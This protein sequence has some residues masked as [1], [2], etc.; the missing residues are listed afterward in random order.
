M[1]KSLPAHTAPRNENADAASLIPH[2][3]VQDVLD[4]AYCTAHNYPGGA[5]ALALRMGMGVS[6]LQLKVSLTTTTHNLNLREAVA[7][8]ALS[9][10]YSVLHAMAGALSHVAMPMP[11]L[12]GGDLQGALVTLG[13]EVGDVFRESARALADGRL[14][15]NERRRVQRQ[16]SEA[17]AALAGVQ[18]ALQAI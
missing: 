2:A 17:M 15:P 11:E 9:G 13:A 16:I 8:Q 14:T 3:G 18:R 4:A 1:P 5:A 7:M 10:D 6:T 12:G